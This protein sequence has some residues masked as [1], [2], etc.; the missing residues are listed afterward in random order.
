MEAWREELYHS[1]QEDALMHYGVK[2]M[3]WGFRNKK[4]DKNKYN[5]HTKGNLLS[6]LNEELYTE[7]Y[8][9]AYELS[10]LAD[11]NRE[12]AEKKAIELLKKYD[13][14]FV[15]SYDYIWEKY[16][17]TSMVQAALKA[18]FERASDIY[19]RKRRMG[20]DS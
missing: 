17:R 11:K 9:E 10:R 2:G 15:N 19:D 20:Y 7:N 13:R 1:M 5:Q 6:Q 4:K 3:K 8:Q 14:N 16:K 12:E 18:L